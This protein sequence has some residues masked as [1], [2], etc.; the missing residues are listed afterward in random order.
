ML[1][2]LLN[3]VNNSEDLLLRLWVFYTQPHI[4]ST[5]D[6]FENI[7]FD[8]LSGARSN[9]KLVEMHNILIFSKWGEKVENKKAYFDQQM[10]WAASVCWLK[11]TI[12]GW[13]EN[14]NKRSGEREDIKKIMREIERER[15]KTRI[16]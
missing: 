16:N 9:W 13:E 10:W 3:V 4:K 8:Q 5:N 15:R 12:R 7:S 1:L 2:S 14:Q 11:Y 6:F